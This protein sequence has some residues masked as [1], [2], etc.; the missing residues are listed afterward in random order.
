MSAAADGPAGAGTGKRIAIVGAGVA[1]LATARQLMAAG[2]DCVLFERGDRI[3]GVWA[4]GYLNFGVQVQ[5]E[6]YEFPDWPLPPAA[7]DFTPG[8]TVQRYLEDYADHF[9]IAPHIRFG[10]AVEDIAP[11]GDGWRLGWREDGAAR[12]DSFD[13]AVVCVGLYS[14]TPYLPQF[15]DEADFTGEVMHVSALKHRPQLKGKRVAIVGF[16]KSATDAALEAAEAADACHIVFREAH[17][18]IPSKLAGVLPFKWGLLNRLCS[19][20]LPPYQTASAL[21]RAVHRLGLPLNW[22]YWRLVEG[23]L[24]VQCRLTSNFG[25]RVSFVP[26]KPIEYDAFGE[27][28]MLPK[29]AF[30]RRARDGG[31]AAH[32]SAVDRFTE[33]GLKL[34]N[35]EEIEADLVIMATGW[36]TRF[37]F[38]SQDVLDRLEPADDG[39][40]LYR[41]ICHPALPG[42]FFVGRAASISSILTYSLQAAWLS[43]LLAGRVALPAAAAMTRNIADMAAWKRRYFPDS[44]SRSARLIAHTQHYHDELL[45]DLGLSPLRKTG[46]FAPLKELIAPYEPRDYAGVVEPAARAEERARSA[47]TAG[48]AAPMPS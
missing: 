12:Q 14:H 3:G 7:P 2:H 46:P 20:L 5:R 28:V 43:E 26:D 35:G 10:R 45:R 34:S 11:D 21:E 33:S 37:R 18:P 6:L 32:R 23:L 9:G 31:I 48:A 36:R 1:G 38:F 25:R 8:P 44:A 16:G 39:I 15:P 29:P 17:W 42:L 47:R 27:S 22:F 41:H 13:L 40:Y 4:D 19:T 24:L 30:F